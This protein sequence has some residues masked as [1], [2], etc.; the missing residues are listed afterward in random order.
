MEHTTH[1]NYSFYKSHP[2]VNL[3]ALQATTLFTNPTHLFF[4][5]TPTSDQTNFR[6]TQRISVDTRFSSCNADSCFHYEMMMPKSVP[7]IFTF[8]RDD[9]SKSNGTWTSLYS[10]LER[11]SILNTSDE[12]LEELDSPLTSIVDK[13]SEFNDSATSNARYKLLRQVWA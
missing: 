3:L 12:E 13:T 9:A 10:S 8:T 5:Q 2:S 7:R 1:E 11:A 6:T 4:H